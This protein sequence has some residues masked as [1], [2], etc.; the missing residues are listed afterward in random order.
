MN[1]TRYNMKSLILLI[2]ILFGILRGYFFFSSKYFYFFLIILGLI[3]I[4]FFLKRIKNIDF[5][6][7]YFSFVIF[8]SSFVTGSLDADY[9]I[10]IM[11]MV[12]GYFSAYYFYSFKVRTKNE[13]LYKPFLYLGFILSILGLY[14]YVLNDLIFKEFIK[15]GYTM[16]LSEKAY[17]SYRIRSFFYHPI[18]YGNFLVITMCINLLMNKHRLSFIFLNILLCVNIVMTQSRSSWIALIVVLLAYKI[19]NRVFKNEIIRNKLNINKYLL[20]GLYVLLSVI[21]TLF[22]WVYI[23][24]I[25]EIYQFIIDRIYD[26]QTSY[27]SISYLQR[28]FAISFILDNFVNNTEFPQMIFGHGIGSSGVFISAQLNS[29][30]SGFVTTDNTYL[31]ILYDL[32]LVGICFTIYTLIRFTKY[33]FSNKPSTFF[34]CNYLI[35]LSIY[36]A[37]FFY[38]VLGW[39]IILYFFF[40]SASL[41]QIEIKNK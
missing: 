5:F 27:G 16:F 22:L 7:I 28:T 17:E 35:F 6:M 19:R 33:F 41:M 15:S 39:D 10:K 23:Q 30:I 32:G 8:F 9:Y 31:D 12:S 4:L 2:T 1:L 13:S 18:I 11:I 37:M 29:Y 21:I 40:L 36:V 25:I 26:L 24:K 20:V 14:E 3:G 38:S 34:I